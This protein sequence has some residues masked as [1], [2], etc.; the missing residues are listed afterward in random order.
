MGNNTTCKVVGVGSVKMRMFDGMVRTLT[1]GRHVPGLKK[2]LISLRT[3]DKI[4]CKIICEGGVMKIARGSLD[5]GEDE[6][7]SV[8]S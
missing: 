7:E 1:D 3:L 2:N 5:E 4:A 8:C 6:W